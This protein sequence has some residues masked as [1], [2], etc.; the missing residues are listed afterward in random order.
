M[1]QERR[2]R[3]CLLLQRDKFEFPHEA[4][5]QLGFERCDAARR[6]LRRCAHRQAEKSRTRDQERQGR[7]ASDSESMGLGVRVIADGAWGF[8]ASDDLS[9]ERLKPRRRAL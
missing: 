3:H 9:R 8:A 6:D 4:N 2:R 7:H 5:R 1:W